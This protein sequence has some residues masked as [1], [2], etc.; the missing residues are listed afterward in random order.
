MI[1]NYIQLK[2]FIAQVMMELKYL[3]QLSIKQINSKRTEQINYICTDMDH[4]D[5]PST[6]LLCHKF[7]PY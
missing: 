4:M 3:C 2:E 6:Q 1:L 7:Y 5:S